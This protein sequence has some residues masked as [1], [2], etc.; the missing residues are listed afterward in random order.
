ME[1]AVVDGK[2]VLPVPALKAQCPS[3]NALVIAKCGRINAW[4]FAHVASDDCDR[5]SEPESEWHQRWKRY[6]PIE[7][8]EVVIKNHRADIKNKKNIIIE[9]QHSHIDVQQM[10]E[11]EEFYKNMVWLIDGSDFFENFEMNYKSYGHS[12]RWKHGHKTWLYATK[13]V[14]IDFLGVIFHVK[15]IGYDDYR[16][17]GWGRIMHVADFVKMITCT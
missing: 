9:L 10:A 7:Q 14:Y 16:V 2:R 11:R 1:I 5:W 8:R 13:P 12:F 17:F 15:K 3:C 6:F 4:H